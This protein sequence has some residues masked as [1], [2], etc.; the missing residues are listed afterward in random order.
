MWLATKVAELIG[1]QVSKGAALQSFM[2]RPPF[3][4]RRPV[5]IGDDSTDLSAFAA[6]EFFGGKGLR[7]AGEFFGREA[8][9]FGGAAEVRQFLSALA[10]SLEA[11]E[12]TRP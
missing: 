8:A 12:E 11:R 9:D 7:V 5:M 6:A 4:D 10:D 2:T 3:A 1:K